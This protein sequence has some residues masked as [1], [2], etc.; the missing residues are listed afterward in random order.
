MRSRRRSFSFAKRSILLV[1]VCSVVIVV[2]LRRGLIPLRPFDAD[3]GVSLSDSRNSIRA[4]ETRDAA[5]RQVK[6][7]LSK[8]GVDATVTVI[9]DHPQMVLNIQGTTIGVSFA[10][11]FVRRWDRLRDLR[12]AG[13]TKI[14]FVKCCG[15]AYEYFGSYDLATDQLR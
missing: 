8:T 5:V 9:E 15:L 14:V 2:L 11:Q 6:T 13:F 3:S 7:I 12:D 1:V 10:H 4:E